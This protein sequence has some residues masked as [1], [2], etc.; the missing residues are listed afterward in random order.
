[1]KF[2]LLLSTAFTLSAS[3][4]D[5]PPARDTFPDTWVATDALGRSLPAAADVRAP[6][7]DR[8]VALFYFLWLGRHG[9]AGPFDISTILAKDPRAIDDPKHPAWGPLHVPHH[10][11][12]PLFD[13][14]V[15]DDRFVLRKHAQML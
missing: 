6:R 4:Q 13:Y 11:G 1:M 7:D 10:W 9:E 8:F 15:S 12:R 5:I 2:L 14:Y 3:A